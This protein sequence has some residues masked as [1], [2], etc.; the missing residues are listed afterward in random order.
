MDKATETV[1]FDESGE[2][3][4]SSVL[5]SLLD[6][7]NANLQQLLTSHSQSQAEMLNTMVQHLTKPKQVIRDAYGKIQGVQ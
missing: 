6:Q 2:A 5:Q 7:S 1:S 4:P 3:K